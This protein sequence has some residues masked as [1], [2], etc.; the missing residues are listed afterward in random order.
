MVVKCCN[1][2]TGWYT[3]RFPLG[4]FET[5]PA[6]SVDVTKAALPGCGE[7]ADFGA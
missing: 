6:D 7:S 4:V 3:C 1:C 2:I 5:A